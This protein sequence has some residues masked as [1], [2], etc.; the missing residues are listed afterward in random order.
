MQGRFYRS[1]LSFPKTGKPHTSSGEKN[2]NRKKSGK[3]EKP[4][5]QSFMLLQLI[6]VEKMVE[7]QQ[8]RKTDEDMEMWYPDPHMLDHSGTVSLSHLSM[9]FL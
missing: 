3:T 8:N 5:I 9:Q 6:L 2:T 1:F 7:N 4:K